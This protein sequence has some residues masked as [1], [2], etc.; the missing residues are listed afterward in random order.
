M[1]VTVLAE[2]RGKN[3]RVAIAG[4]NKFEDPVSPVYPPAIS[5]WRRVLEGFDV[6]SASFVYE[7][8]PADLGHTFPQ[9]AGLVSVTERQ[10][11]LFNGWLKH[12]RAM[13]YRVSSSDSN[14]QPMPQG[15]WHD[16]L[17]SEHAQNMKRSVQ[18]E[19]GRSKNEKKHSPNSGGGS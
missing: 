18:N 1:V 12:R 13:L 5:A 19:S 3:A 14:V 7:L 16:L 4:R 15:L 10:E 8:I 11:A 2:Q 17:T 6:Q 9:P